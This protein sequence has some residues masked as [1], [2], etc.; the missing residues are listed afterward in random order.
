MTLREAIKR[1]KLGS[2]LQDLHIDRWTALLERSGISTVEKLVGLDEASAESLLQSLL[3]YGKLLRNVILE[4]RANH[5]KIE[6][7]SQESRMDK[8]P[9]KGVPHHFWY[10]GP[11]MLSLSALGYVE[12]VDQVRG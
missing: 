11:K 10:R 9:S 6:Q 3:P 1:T 2:L 12:N 7:K 4:I 5:S 8:A